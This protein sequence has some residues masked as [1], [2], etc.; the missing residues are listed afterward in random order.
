MNA[1]DL[2]GL[3]IVTLSDAHKVGSIGEVLFDPS[4]HQVL[5]FEVKQGGLFHRSEAVLRSAVTAI[6]QDAITIAAPTDVNHDDRYPELKTARKL[7]DLTGLK[8]VTERGTMLGTI[9]EVV[10]DSQARVIERY[11][12]DTSLLEKLRREEHV[13]LPDQVVRLGEDNIMIVREAVTGASASAPSP[14]ATV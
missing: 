9:G 2:L 3:G 5:A 8:V 13:I 10:L 12:L 1:K 4:L 11:L 7:S 6:G 14:Q